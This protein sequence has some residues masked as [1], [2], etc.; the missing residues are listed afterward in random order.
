[1]HH[2][3]DPAP[4]THLPRNDA[5]TRAFLWAM[6]ATLEGED[7]AR[8]V[9][10]TEAGLRDPG[11]TSF[12]AMALRVEEIRALYRLGRY[13]AADDRLAS[14]WRIVVAHRDAVALTAA[15]K[16]LWRTSAT[17]R[18]SATITELDRTNLELAQAVGLVTVPA[19]RHGLVALA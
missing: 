14:L 5:R 4:T 10:R 7:L 13:A 17:P 8:R 9:R 15:W 18:I 12:F 19:E 2:H 1:M 3:F 11:S 16:G 6:S